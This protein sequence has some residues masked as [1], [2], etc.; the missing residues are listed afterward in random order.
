VGAEWLPV[1][2]PSSWG[3][4]AQILV[5]IVM[6]LVYSFIASVLPVWILLQPRAY[7]N[8]HQLF[9]GLGLLYLSLLIARPPMTAPMFIPRYEGDPII[10]FLFVTIACGAISG[11]HGLVSSG[12]TSKQVNRLGDTKILGYGGMLGEGALGLMAVL[13]CTAGFM[14]AKAWHAAYH[15]WEGAQQGGVLAFV[16]G[17]ARILEQGLA[18]DQWFP[19]G[20]LLARTLLAVIVIAF[21]ATTLDTACRI[22]RYILGEL[23][24]AYRMPVLKNRYLGSA[25]AAF[26]PILLVLGR[27]WSKL[28]PI[29][30]SANQVM[31]ALSMLVLTV[32]LVRKRI[33]PLCTLLPLCFL[34]LITGTAMGIKLWTFWRS[35]SWLLLG[36]TTILLGF[37]IWIVVEAV[38]V[39][40]S[41]LLNPAAAE[42]M[43][44]R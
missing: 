44:L 43:E 39:Y 32:Y 17:G 21:G 15:S 28:W 7:I 2:L 38:F 6:L 33:N 35:G 19:S 5:W 40:R 42:G 31:A 13:A 27:S 22:Q 16:S 9:V 1:S 24:E 4:D 3:V 41:Y 18:V 10:P 25:I 34:V 14:S 23:G 8:S 36:V 26:T 12:T 37:S 29:F 11:F 20:A 30:G